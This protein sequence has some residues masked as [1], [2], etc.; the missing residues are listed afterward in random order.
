[1]DGFDDLLSRSGDVLDNPFADARS[2]SPDPWASY[3]QPSVVRDDEHAVFLGTR[4]TTPTL[5]SPG[6]TDSAGFQ[7][8]ASDAN[9]YDD[10][11]SAQHSEETGPQTPTADEAEVESHTPTPPALASP[12]FRESVPLSIDELTQPADDKPL[13]EPSPPPAQPEV[14]E[15]PTPPATAPATYGSFV[16]HASRPSNA[17]TFRAEPTYHS[18]LGQTSTA[19]ID[20]SLAG[21]SMSGEAF[22]GWQNEANTY[23]TSPQSITGPSHSQRSRSDSD[24]SDDDRPILQSAR[25][26]NRIP[27]AQASRPA[28]QRTENGLPPAFVITVD[29]PQKVGDPIRA[30]TM[31]TVHTKTTS[32]LFSKSSFSVLRRYSD[33]LWLYETLSQNNPGV[34][35]PPVPEKNPYRR[36]DQGFVEQRRL[37]LEKCMQKIANHPVLQKDADLRMFLESDTFSLDVKHRKAELGQEKGFMASLGQSIAGPR[38]YETDEWFDRQKAYLDSLESQLRGLVKAIDMV[39]K[40]RSEVALATGEFAQ[41]ITDLASSDIGPQLSTSFTGLADV[42]RKAQDLHTVQSQDDMV[43]IM[44]TVDEY[45]RLINSVR[46]AFSSRIRTYHQWQTADAHLRSTKQRHE[47]QRAQGRLPSDQLS[48]SL[49]MVA[50]AERRALDAKTEFDQT[51]RL[52]KT[53]VARFEQER[54]EDFKNSLEAFLDGMIARQKEL[55]STWE[56][57]QQRMLK[58]AVPAGQRRNTDAVVAPVS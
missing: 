35:V 39:A 7:Y 2:A 29:D 51:S 32:P 38:F 44:S 28:A 54:I 20:S 42:E 18:P 14:P 46:M 48:R 25:L 30:Y 12:G 36:F 11:Y 17:S 9:V 16:G 4:S 6:F 31:Y 57:Y 33:F 52:V 3:G 24:S 23:P 13:R 49:S 40:H 27:P 22:N 5:E 21:L 56:N 55:I 50:D 1:M 15:S 45:A 10:H 34:V 41:T 37:A 43:T 26:A 19:G 8:S 58:V 47:S 53:E